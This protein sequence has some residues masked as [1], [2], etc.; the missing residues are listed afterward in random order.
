MR[1]SGAVPLVE[2]PTDTQMHLNKR[3][4]IPHSLIDITVKSFIYAP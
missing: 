1:L 3:E 2:G 4:M